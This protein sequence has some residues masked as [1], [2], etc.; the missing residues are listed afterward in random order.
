METGYIYLITNMVNKK[1]YVGQTT[2]TVEERWK[3]HL[4]EVRQPR[5]ERYSLYRAIRKYGE[6]SFCVEQL[7][8][9]ESKTVEELQACLN[10]LEILEIERH[11]SYDSGYNLTKGGR[12]FYHL[13]IPIARYTLEGDLVCTYP[14]MLSVEDD[15]F[16]RYSVSQACAGK[17]RQHGGFMWKILDGEVEAKIPP[18]VKH[19]PS[20][21][22]F[23][24][25]AYD[26][27]DGKLVGT[28]SSLYE[29]RVAHKIPIQL[30]TIEKG[31]KHGKYRYVFYED[32]PQPILQ[33][34][35]NSVKAPSFCVAQ[36]ALDG[37][38]LQTFPKIADAS[39]AMTGR[40]K[41]GLIS[42]AI[43]KS[44]NT[45]YGYKWALIEKGD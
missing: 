44:R 14:S 11:K 41:D 25:A 12:T 32:A 2:K 21:T 20:K 23:K 35:V 39:E 40:R 4:S 3:T 9:V 10:E 43:R 29:I 7:H 42:A 18:Y 5:S 1:N 6:D 15:G 22:S 16:S 33:D 31:C 8:K 13:T 17:L 45:A 24:I 30:R 28:F 27:D 37:T 38:L 34:K 19:T 26:D 36:Y